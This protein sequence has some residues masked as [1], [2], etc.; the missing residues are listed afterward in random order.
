MRLHDLLDVAQLLHQ[1]LVDL[2]TSRRID[3]HDIIRVRCR[4]SD[5]SARDGNG[6]L[7]PLRKHGNTDLFADDREL[8]DGGG[9]I[10]IVRHEERTFALLFQHEGEL[11]RRGRLTRALETDK[12][13]DR[14]R[15][16][17]DIEPALRPAHELREL[18]VDDLDD[19][20]RCCE[21]V[22]YFLPDGT[23]L[24]ALHE[25]L[26]DLEIDVCFEQRHAH[27]AHRIVHVVL[28]QFAVSAHFLKDALQAVG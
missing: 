16:W 5:R 10:D 13:D 12:H 14:R 20:L 9:A 4:V 24:D 8:L 19:R 25:I 7:L 2:Q 28:G 11:A 17:A 15:V 6:I 21:R 26:N 1:C 23:L 3:D 27:L 18:L 22:E